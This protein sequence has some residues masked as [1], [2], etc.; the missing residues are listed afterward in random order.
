MID[1]K[2]ARNCCGCG[3]CACACPKKCIDIR[4][5]EE[6]FDYPVINVEQCID[7]KL[8]EKICP[9]NSVQEND[10]NKQVY[11]GWSTDEEILLNSSSGG[12]FG[13]I[14]EIWLK[15]GGIVYAAGYDESF[16]VVHK[17]A[18]RRK[19]L[20]E[21]R[22]SKYVQSR[23]GMIFKEIKEE[24]LS[25]KKIL[26]VGTP[27]QV[28]ALR[29]YVG[30]SCE[31]LLLIDLKCHG[32]P[33]PKLWSQYILYIKEKYELEDIK[34]INFR[35]KSNGWHNFNMKIEGKNKTYL[36][37]HY[38]DRF[39][40]PFFDNRALRMS[41]YKCEFNNSAADITLADAW[42]V[43]HK[44]KELYDVTKYNKGISL[45][46]FNSE[47]GQEWQK[48]IEAYGNFI[49]YSSKM[50]L[51]NPHNLPLPLDRKIFFDALNKISPM[52]FFEKYCKVGLKIKIYV[53]I[54]IIME[55]LGLMNI[56]RKIKNK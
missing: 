7:C 32:V 49:F 53:Y 13:T 16:N 43:E 33:S 56:I 40:V 5:N 30:M 24:L 48:N 3:A 42:N 11:V 39:L 28:S 12:F 8:C 1:I 55:H 26:F 15:E 21:L 4:R 29:N 36:K 41:C 18:N 31:N 17:R 50:E 23:T 27:C 6:G 51:Q 44:H 22:T 34:S 9:Y 2:D 19:E 20:L 47:K 38:F 35:N 54:R 52:N 25:G 14:A 10:D 37:N 46:G 45:V